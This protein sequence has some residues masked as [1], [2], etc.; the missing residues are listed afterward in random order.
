MR[1]SQFIPLQEHVVEDYDQ[2]RANQHTFKKDFL[3][4]KKKGENL[5]DPPENETSTEKVDRIARE[6]SPLLG[7]N[8]KKHI[9]PKNHFRNDAKKVKA[10]PEKCIEAYRLIQKELNDTEIEDLYTR[11]P[12]LMYEMDENLPVEFRESNEFGFF[13]GVPDDE[14]KK[15][16]DLLDQDDTWNDTERLELVLMLCVKAFQEKTDDGKFTVA[17]VLIDVVNSNINFRLTDQ[18]ENDLAVKSILAQ[19]G[20]SNGTFTSPAIAIEDHKSYSILRYV[21]RAFGSAFSR[22]GLG[23]NFRDRFRIA[24]GLNIAGKGKAD[25]RGV[26]LDYLEKTTSGTTAGIDFTQPTDAD[27]KREKYG[28]TGKVDLVQ[29]GEEGLLEISGKNLPFASMN[30]QGDDYT[31]QSD[32]G[33]FLGLYLNITWPKPEEQ[34]NPIGEL[35][36]HIADTS[37]L[38]ELYFHNLRISMP[39]S[40]F[41]MGGVLV[42]GLRFS[43][44]Q[45]FVNPEK[46]TKS[47]IIPSGISLL[48]DV[49]SILQLSIMQTISR[50]T[51][52]NNAAEAEGRKNDMADFKKLLEDKGLHTYDL[53]LSYESLE[54]TNLIYVDQDLIKD[55]SGKQIDPNAKNQASV[56]GKITTG[57]TSI[58]L[59]SAGGPETANEKNSL[60]AM[61]TA[62]NTAEANL[63]KATSDFNFYSNELKG[64]ELSLLKT[65]IEKRE[66]RRLEK[67]KSNLTKKQS[68]AAKDVTKYKT[69]ALEIRQLIG[70]KQDDL[71][72]NF[73]MT[74]TDLTFSNGA[75]LDEL[76]SGMLGSFADSMSGVGNASVKSLTLAST[77]ST[78]GISNLSLTTTGIEIPQ[79]DINGIHVHSP[80]FA[81]TADR[82]RM[83]NFKGT[84]G[85]GFKDE[86]PVPLGSGSGVVAFESKRKIS[87]LKNDLL[88]LQQVQNPDATTKDRQ[89][90][91]EK[92]IAQE[93]KNY[94]Q[95][96]GLIAHISLTSID[97]PKTDLE[98]GYLELG[99]KAKTFVQFPKDNPISLIGLNASHLTLKFDADKTSVVPEDSVSQGHAELFSMVIPQGTSIKQED[100]LHQLKLESKLH[101]IHADKLKIDL[102]QNGT[103]NYELGD[104]QGGGSLT[105]YDDKGSKHESNFSLAEK[106]TQEPI[107]KGS[108]SGNV[109]TA[110]LVLPGMETDMMDIVTDDASFVIPKTDKPAFLHTITAD[111]TANL[112]PDKNAENGIQSLAVSSARV[113]TIFAQGAT[114]KQ[115]KY[116]AAFGPEQSVE[117]HGLYMNNL[118]LDTVNKDAQELKDD[119]KKLKEGET[120]KLTKLSRVAPTEGT[121]KAGLESSAIPNGFSFDVGTTL[122]AIMRKA[123]SEKLEVEWL[124][125]KDNTES[126]NKKYTFV[127]LDAT[128]KVTKY[129]EDGKNK[130]LEIDTKVDTRKG[131]V[132]VFKDETIKGTA[133][134]GSEDR[135]QQY[136]EGSVDIASINIKSL[137]VISG[138]DYFKI[139]ANSAQPYPGKAQNLI[140]NFKLT[141]LKPS[142]KMEADAKTRRENAKN[143]LASHAKHHMS[144]KTKREYEAET[145]YEAKA[146]VKL[147]L[148]KL[149]LQHLEAYGLQMR[150]SSESD[151]NNDYQYS[152]S[153]IQV[154]LDPEQAMTMNTVAFDDFV[155]EL[156]DQDNTPAGFSGSVSMADFNSGALNFVSDTVT[157]QLYGDKQTGSSDANLQARLKTGKIV[158]TGNDKRDGSFSMTVNDPQFFMPDKKTIPGGFETNHLYLDEGIYHTSTHYRE[159][160]KPKSTF[161]MSSTQDGET[162]DMLGS[163]QLLRQNE[164]AKALFSAGQFIFSRERVY[165]D[166]E[167]TDP[168]KDERGR[169]V[170]KN[171]TKIVN[172]VLNDLVIELKDPLAYW[173]SGK[174]STTKLTVGGNV[175]GTLVI[176]E[177]DNVD[178]TDY[179]SPHKSDAT[180]VANTIEKALVNAAT[181]K[182]KSLVIRT[183]PGDVLSFTSAKIEMTNET[184]P[185]T[186]EGKVEDTEASL[187]KYKA[188]KKPSTDFNF[189]DAASGKI[190]ISLFGTTVNMP[191]VQINERETIS[192]TKAAGRTTYTVDEKGEMVEHTAFVDLDTAVQKISNS[193]E[194]TY[195]DKLTGEE[196]E[197]LENNPAWSLTRL[198]MQI[199]EGDY[200]LVTTG[201]NDIM[202]LVP[203]A[204]ENVKRFASQ[205][206]KPMVR[207]SAL[208][209]FMANQPPIKREVL[210]TG[211]WHP[212]NN[213]IWLAQYDITQMLNNPDMAFK[214]SLN[215][216]INMKQLKGNDKVATA[217]ERGLL[218]IV[219]G[220]E[221][222]N[223]NATVGLKQKDPLFVDTYTDNLD[224]QTTINGLKLGA[225]RYV[226]YNKE[227]KHGEMV[228]S[229]SAL[230]LTKATYNVETPDPLFND[231]HAQSKSVLNISGLN[232]TDFRIDTR[233]K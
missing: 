220:D 227:K 102:L 30:V 118:K 41:A 228:V 176:E 98:N 109:I 203:D 142:A 229:G 27:G 222:V 121:F 195:K 151:L 231:G 3:K 8:N 144:S 157:K 29:H 93:E 51:D 115:G 53:S 173:G 131:E 97:V 140:G 54:I 166:K 99:K 186:D 19:Y 233:Q 155:L 37:H 69:E 106:T 81:F 2:Y 191:V 208:V 196:K 18:D 89:T 124:K 138:T 77:I 167:K 88:I 163:L 15:L 78:K 21:G 187:E 50:F 145:K 141:I 153:T 52:P 67:D 40:S 94:A 68:V 120:L 71:A 148:P 76:G 223:F 160:Y 73:S 216:D 90:E 48:M 64:V 38:D 164:A 11:Y 181:D 63:T 9:Q 75:M 113:E 224:Y 111:V 6:I 214:L 31:F 130:E 24:S 57:Q 219:Q 190:A 49:M 199:S 36:V 112:N 82:A 44:A 117:V 65:D 226:N 47:D 182:A 87:A 92:T 172:P 104:L 84:L 61:K 127:N 100:L 55:D 143:M 159:P 95:Q 20:F 185:Y 25:L 171:V 10:D 215:V 197:K 201:N 74:T 217:G 150:V 86:T 209:D 154:R 46:F 45:S 125:A 126:G 72:L 162:T 168:K 230:T 200:W 16:L 1:Q 105:Q 17:S 70:E 32:D 137:D 225:F 58:S 165:K 119:Q 146:H 28:T 156:P 83:H 147:E 4:K 189:L 26:S 204:K 180:G 79:L 80:A 188:N 23:Y 5:I 149:T 34:E 66:Q 13:D 33:H 114:F 178:F 85:I 207:L 128:G 134:D 218:N 110:N 205:G 202:P 7:F 198:G 91:L 194:T 184:A 158:V 116:K 96:F 35:L 59:N 103:L 221:K 136:I 192:V 169:P 193:L 129:D 12:T 122:K 211:F 210:E 152:Q 22:G 62:L 123:T 39:D 60:S 108:K 132:T 232:I 133:K 175:I 206:N 174:T 107:I 43:L 161:S 101:T 183:E 177:Q 170:F 42:K 212:I 56:I 14:K 139:P 179:N 213:M 135:I